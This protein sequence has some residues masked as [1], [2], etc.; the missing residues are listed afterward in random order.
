MKA[1]IGLG[2]PEGSYA[3]TR[4]NVGFDIVN[5]L[6]D[7]FSTK[8]SSGK[9]P[10][11]VAKG[12][13]RGE[14]T[15][16]IKPITFMN[17]SGEAVV[18]ALNWY[19]ILPEDCLICYDDLNLPVGRIRLRE[20]GSAGGHNGVS[21]VI[22]KLGTKNFPRLR[23]GIGNNFARGQ[24]ASYVLSKF[25]KSELKEVEDALKLARDAALCFASKGIEEAMNQ[26]N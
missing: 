17:R 23:F 5:L 16:C 26:Y 3:G 12:V 20:S 22:H 8:W 24:Q 18:A 9:G 25:D 7:Y 13:Y 11:S 14:Q 21:D 19:K 2:N 1:I 6:S 15:V 4:H 10:F